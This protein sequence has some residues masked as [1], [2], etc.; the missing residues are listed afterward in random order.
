METTVNKVII[1]PQPE[2]DF[3]AYVPKLPGCV[4]QGETYQE[5]HQNIQEALELYIDVAKERHIS[6][7]N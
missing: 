5:A 6:I 7:S 2:D 3:T 4:S 1:E